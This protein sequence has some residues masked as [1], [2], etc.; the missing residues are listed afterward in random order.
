MKRSIS[1]KN[2][3]LRKRLSKKRCSYKKIGGQ[4]LDITYAIGHCGTSSRMLGFSLRK[5]CFIIKNQPTNTKVVLYVNDNGN[6]EVRHFTDINTDTYT[7]KVECI[8][9]KEIDLFNILIHNFNISYKNRRIFIANILD[10]VSKNITKIYK[11]EILK[12]ILVQYEQIYDN[13]EPKRQQAAIDEINK[14][15]TKIQEELNTCYTLL[16]TK[17]FVK[18]DEGKAV[19]LDKQKKQV[20]SPPA[21]FDDLLKYKTAQINSAKDC[22]R[23]ITDKYSNHSVVASDIE[24]MNATINNYQLED[25]IMIN[26]NIKSMQLCQASSV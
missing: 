14:L 19:C 5:N 2:L 12:N 10:N 13:K 23:I 18:Y 16:D 8:I 9:S 21:S 15:K 4:Q 11:G 17:E 24:N 3:L 20:V 7:D 6:I 25:N 22:V 1:N 26:G